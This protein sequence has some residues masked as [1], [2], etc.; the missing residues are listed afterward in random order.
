VPDYTGLVASVNLGYTLLGATR[1]AVQVDRDV[2]FSYEQFQ[3]YYVLTGVTGTVTHRLTSVWDLQARAGNQ[4]LA[5]RSA[6]LPTG[7]AG[8]APFAPITD[9]TDN[10]VF[11]GG[12]VGYHIGPD[13]RLGFNVDYY[14]RRSDV[15]INQYEGLRVGSSV[16]YGF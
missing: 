6:I 2:Q 5:Y 7:G 1:F 3:P 14:T 8:T 4:Q 11:Y 15:I 12:G 9:R 13:I 10:V 16:T